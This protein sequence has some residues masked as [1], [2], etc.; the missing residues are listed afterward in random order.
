MTIRDISREYVQYWCKECDSKESAASMASQD[1]AY[2][3]IDEIENWLSSADLSK[4][5]NKLIEE[6]YEL[7]K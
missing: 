4:G 7:F 1:T 5:K 6:L 2:T 3:V